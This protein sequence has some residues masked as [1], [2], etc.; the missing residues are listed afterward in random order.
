MLKLFKD[1]TGVTLIETLVAISLFAVTSSIAMGILIESGRLEKKETIQTEIYTD[2]EAVLD[3]IASE[4]SNGAI[5]YEEY[6]SVCVLQNA[7]ALGS[8]NDDVY[9][10]VNYGVYASRFFDPGRRLTEGPYKNPKDL[11][12]ECTF[13]YP[14]D[15]LTDTC[16]NLYTLSYDLNT[17][18][19]PYTG[20]GDSENSASAFCDKTS[21]LCPPENYAM[22]DQLFLISAN[23]RKKTILA[24]KKTFSYGNDADYAIG[25]VEMLGSD[26][27]QNTNIDTFSCTSDYSCY[28]DGNG[29]SGFFGQLTTITNDVPQYINSHMFSVPKQ[30]DLDVALD[31]ANLQNTSFVPITPLRISITDLK[32]KISPLEDPIKA[33]AEDSVQQKPSVTII[34]TMDLAE[35]QKTSYPGTFQPVTMQTTVVAG[36]STTESIYPPVKNVKQR[37]GGS[38]MRNVGGILTH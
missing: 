21:G 34:L 20:S 5:D 16:Q 8:A 36:G 12:V 6:Y 28:G 26:E 17:G 15:P 4:I 37:K 11:G 30:N 13:P 35:N 23:G 24:R 9:Y 14:F 31:I 38:W 19:N 18:K 7:C 27:D 22:V 1:N 2:M 3:I 25:K 33:F 10:G 32:F 29:L